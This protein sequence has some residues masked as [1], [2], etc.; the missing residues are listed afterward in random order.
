MAGPA[1]RESIERGLQAEEFLSSGHGVQNIMKPGRL[2]IS[3]DDCRLEASPD[4]LTRS[5][6]DC[7]FPFVSVLVP[8]RNEAR[9]IEGTI[10]QLITQD[11]PADRFEIL[12][13]D[14]CSKDGTRELAESLAKTHPNL[15]ILD[16]PV[17][18]SSA[19]RNVGIQH[20]RGEFIV[21][22][23]G[24]CELESRSY[25]R[26]LIEAFRA[27]GADCLGRPQSL[28]VRTASSVQRAIAAARSAPLGHH[29]DSFI[30]AS[31]EQFV[32]AKSVAVAYRRSVLDQV[33]PFDESFDAC[34]DVELNHR[35]DRAGL[36]CFFTPKIGMSYV[37]RSSLQGL[38]HQLARYGRGRV[39]LLRKHPE[40]FS[41]GGFIPALWLSGL[42]LG[43]LACLAC[44]PLWWIYGGVIALYATILLVAAA[45]LASRHRN[46]WFLVLLPA[47]F[48]TI[49]AGSG[50]GILWELLRP[51]RKAP[52]IAAEEEP[53]LTSAVLPPSGRAEPWAIGLVARS[54]TVD[55]E[56]FFTC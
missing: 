9:F 33:G 45:S 14:G 7:G 21:I 39:R 43:P 56:E 49:H 42:A 52:L 15:R 1:R 8:V 27:S 41:P 6:T 16:N 51:A 10:G 46:Y 2:S 17:R 11:Y 25:L 48:V 35:I 28:D 31:S 34:E 29:P 20:S 30:Y 3:G 4:T 44:P 23:D 47:V 55:T 19:A 22:V 13:V 18:L 40:T 26:D 24:H 37:P 12:I 54:Q 50:W 36:R 38:F 32:P 5:A 53:E